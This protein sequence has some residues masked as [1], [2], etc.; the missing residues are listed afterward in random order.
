MILTNFV[1][2]IKATTFK[3]R[4]TVTSLLA[5][6]PNKL[7]TSRNILQLLGGQKTF[8]SRQVNQGKIEFG[9]RR[10]QRHIFSLHYYNHKKVNLPENEIRI[11]V[12][13]YV[14]T[15]PSTFGVIIMKR[16]QE[17]DVGKW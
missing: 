13:I 6:E 12:R 7:T 2:K 5:P 8:P 14:K 3:V 9:G 16:N 4:T 10:Y 15:T 11:F 1:C 17:V